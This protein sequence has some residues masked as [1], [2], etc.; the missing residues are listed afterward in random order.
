MVDDFSLLPA[1][2]FITFFFFYYFIQHCSCEKKSNR[3]PPTKISFFE[4]VKNKDRILEW[5]TELVL[6]SPTY[7]ITMPSTVITSNPKNIEHILKTNF[8]NYPKGDDFMAIFSELLGHGIINSDGDHWKLQRKAAS[9]EF[10]TKNIRT[11]ILDKVGSEVADRLVLLLSKAAATGASLDLHDLLDRLAIDNVCQIVSD[12]DPA[13]LGHGNVDVRRFIHA[14]EAV[15]GVVN[16]RFN[17]PCFVWKLQRLLGVGSERRLK[18]EIGDVH[19]FAMRIVK[20]RKGRKPEEIR[21][22]SDFLSHSVL[23]GNSSDEFLR[24]IIINF[25]FAARETTPTAMTW[26][27]W[28]VSTRPEVEERILDEIDSVRGRHGNHDGKLTMD[29]LREMDYLH[30]V[31]SETL[32]LYPPVPLCPRH[33]SEDDMLPDGT[34]VKKRWR[35]IYNSYAMGAMESIWGEDCKEFKPE[36]WLENGVFRP[37]SPFQFPVFHAGPRTCL[38][39]ETAYIQMKALAASVIERFSFEVAATT[40]VE[41]ISTLKMKGG[42]PVSVREKQGKRTCKGGGDL[43]MA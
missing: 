1:L 3:E 13:W 42:F 28:L 30:A 33:C 11:I 10:S 36:R 29:E 25:V 16:K 6:A 7:T 4:M 19:E 41:F 17:Q 20:Q 5:T 40:E 2:L 32:R 23:N 35:V 39:K 22:S 15:L 21:S 34:M 26:F 8:R 31:L 37:K 43:A 14:F 12:V 38:G 27:F 18:E 24:D 9:R